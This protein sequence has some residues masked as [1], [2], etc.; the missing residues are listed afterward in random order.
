MNGAKKIVVIGGGA[1]G[2]ETAYW[3]Q[4][5]QKCDVTVL[6]MLP[7]MIDGACTANRGH[8]IHYFEEAGGKLINCAK[9]V[10]F[11]ANNAVK[12]ERNISKAVPDPYCTWTPIIPK[13]VENP[14]A[15]KMGP[16]CLIETVP[17]ELIVLCMG[18]AANDA[19]YYEAVEQRVAPE[20][21]NIGDSL[22]AGNLLTGNRAAWHIAAKV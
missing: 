5:E 13:N 11:G 3:L 12:I 20:I 15:P 8:L 19:P 14:L 17:S 10:G 1:V 2:L 21:Y 16:E 18:R 7:Y 4:Y 9:V 6:E 22:E